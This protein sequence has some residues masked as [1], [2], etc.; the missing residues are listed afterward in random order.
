VATGDRARQ[1][2]DDVVAVEIARDMPHRAVRMEMMAVEGGDS[3][4]LL[5]PVL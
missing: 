5:P 2:A 3:R 4:C 1:R